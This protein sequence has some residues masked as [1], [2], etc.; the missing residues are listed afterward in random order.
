MA[1]PTIARTYQPYTMHEALDAYA[2]HKAKFLEKDSLGT[3]FICYDERH[4]YQGAAPPK[5]KPSTRELLG[6][7]PDG[8][9]ISQGQYCRGFNML[10]TWED[11]NNEH[12]R[13]P[14]GSRVA[15][16][17]RS[18]PAPAA[19]NT[20]SGCCPDCGTRHP[21]AAPLGWEGDDLQ[22]PCKN[23]NCECH[24]PVADGDAGEDEVT[25][26]GIVH[27]S[28]HIELDYFYLKE[29]KGDSLKTGDYERESLSAEEWMQRYRSKCTLVRVS[30]LR[31]A[32]LSRLKAEWEVKQREMMA[33]M[34]IQAEKID[35]FRY[36]IEY[37]IRQIDA[38][39]DAKWIRKSLAE[40]LDKV[41]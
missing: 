3:F 23:P 9:I 41:R 35:T 27:P 2:E 24:S 16:C 38:E 28:G 15:S 32:E 10:L 22:G 37:A 1:E 19:D 18:L 31:S 30:L 21:D 5:W 8:F 29:F 20:V 39:H 17:L 34:S 36:G 11:A 4:E 6:I 26:W 25:G 14:D 33:F 7:T 12:V 13:W 40:T